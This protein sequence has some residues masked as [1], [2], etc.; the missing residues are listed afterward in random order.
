[1][2]LNEEEIGKTYL[3]QVG[4]KIFVKHFEEKLAITF[5]HKRLGKVSYKRLLRLECY[6][7]YKHLLEEGNYKPFVG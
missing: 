4:R 2:G 6:K 3:N 7:L 5:K 1:L